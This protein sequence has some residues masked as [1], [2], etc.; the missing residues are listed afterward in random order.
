MEIPT[1]TPSPVVKNI[2]FSAPLLKPSEKVDLVLNA[3]QIQHLNQSELPWIA[4]HRALDWLTKRTQ[5]W[6]QTKD[7]HSFYKDN[8]EDIKS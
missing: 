2:K 7:L 5:D 4:W 1:L 8:C 3:L 6:I